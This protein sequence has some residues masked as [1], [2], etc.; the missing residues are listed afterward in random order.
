MMEW[1][2]KLTCRVGFEVEGRCG[3]FFNIRFGVYGPLHVKAEE[4]SG[5]E[6][7]LAG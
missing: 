5:L 6:E 3:E 4:W 2:R 7:L 1:V